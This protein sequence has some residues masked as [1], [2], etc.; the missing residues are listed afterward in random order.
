MTTRR[1]FFAP[2]DSAAQAARV[3]NAGM[4]AVP[5]TARLPF[6]KNTR[7]VID[8]GPLLTS[9]WACTGE[10]ARAYFATSSESP[11]YGLFCLCS[12][13]LKNPSSRLLVLGSQLSS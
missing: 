6:R 13:D 7:L 3:R 8:I 9:N 1:L 11:Q 2:S 4:P 10:G 5:T 12:N